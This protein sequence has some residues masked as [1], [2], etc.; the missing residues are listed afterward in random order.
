[1]PSSRHIT[2]I[3]GRYPY[4]TSESAF[5]AYSY[6]AFRLPIAVTTEHTSSAT[7][8][9]RIITCNYPSARCTL[10]ETK[11]QVTTQGPAGATICGISCRSS[12]SSS[13]PWYFLKMMDLCD[14]GGLI[15]REYSSRTTIKQSIGTGKRRLS[16]SDIKAQVH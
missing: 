16:D 7:V 6:L 4:S 11:R 14:Q 10:I 2:T 12:P 13:S 5:I 1:M 8:W 3:G 9:Y 15:R